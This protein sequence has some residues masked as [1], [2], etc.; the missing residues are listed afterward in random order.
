MLEDRDTETIAAMGVVMDRER[1]DEECQEKAENSDAV[2]Y[3]TEQK[4]T[5][6]DVNIN[7]ELRHLL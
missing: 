4:E 7:P 3:S 1:E 5:R 2:Y 6:K